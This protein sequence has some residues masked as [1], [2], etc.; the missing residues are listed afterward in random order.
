M[1]FDFNNEGVA[2]LISKSE[3]DV[4]DIKSF[5]EMSGSAAIPEKPDTSVEEELIAILLFKDGEHWA[6]WSNK[7]A[8]NLKNGKGLK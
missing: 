5:L 4:S 6:I 3:E 7:Y 2:R 1:I 8:V